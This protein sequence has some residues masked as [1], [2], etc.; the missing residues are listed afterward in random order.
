MI[1]IA[2]AGTKLPTI[3]PNPVSVSQNGPFRVG[4]STLRYRLRHAVV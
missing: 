2:V 3:D 4:G 1:L